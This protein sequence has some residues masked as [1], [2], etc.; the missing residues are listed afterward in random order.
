MTHPM[1]T[2]ASWQDRF[3]QR[4]TGLDWH[5]ARAV[6]RSCRPALQELHHDR[7]LLAEMV[8][9]VRTTPELMSR[10]EE[11]PLM[12]RTVLHHNSDE[13][14]QLRLH[15]AQASTRDLMPHDHKSTFTALILAGGY[16]HVWRR[17]RGEQSGEFSSPDLTT[18]TVSL[19]RPGTCYTFRNSLIHQTVMLPGT[20]TLFVRG[21]NLQSLWH[22]AEDMRH[23][24]DG[25]E[26][27]KA[28]GG[29]YRGGAA[30]SE[31]RF[32][33][34]QRQLV[35]AAVIPPSKEHA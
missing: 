2:V 27:P 3:D 21:P 20:V 28:D 12:F 23:L 6:F 24:L 32:L 19:E 34:L 22:S 13:N 18:G 26:P 9:R 31:E 8:D 33:G 4:V 30:L 10:C 16:V 25:Y 17:R 1:A 11:H 14:V 29:A 35:D 7:E 15:I 5:D